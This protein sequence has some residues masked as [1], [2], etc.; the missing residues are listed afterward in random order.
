MIFLALRE[1]K[2]EYIL[3]NFQKLMNYIN[4][5]ELVASTPNYSD[6]TRPMTGLAIGDVIYNTDD[7]QLNI[8][9]GS[10]WTIPDG[11]GT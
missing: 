10:Q 3:E 8:W 7:G 11:T 1:I 9:D 5:E 6:T 4:K 2:D